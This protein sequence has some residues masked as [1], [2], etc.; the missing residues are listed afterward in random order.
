VDISSKRDKI[1]H[2][3]RLR[4]ARPDLVRLRGN[5]QRGE[6]ERNQQESRRDEQR[7]SGRH[8]FSEERS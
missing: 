5:R 7:A 1:P 3:Y 4:D 6:T 8:T 2:V